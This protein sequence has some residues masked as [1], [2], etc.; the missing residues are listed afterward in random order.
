MHISA[1]SSITRIPLIMG[2]MLQHS[3]SFP[4][5]SLFIFVWTKRKLWS[6]LHL[7]MII[8]RVAS[9]VASRSPAYTSR[10]LDFLTSMT[11]P[12]IQTKPPGGETQPGSDVPPNSV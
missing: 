8:P 2:K 9:R 3:L 6:P 7:F 11:V 4:A 5:M 10:W 12:S 1:D